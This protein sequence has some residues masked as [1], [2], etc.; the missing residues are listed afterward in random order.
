VRPRHEA[1][2]EASS[3][4]L[5]TSRRPAYSRSISRKMAATFKDA[6]EALYKLRKTFGDLFEEHM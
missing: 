5:C 2:G 4:K 3:A 6:A 1:S